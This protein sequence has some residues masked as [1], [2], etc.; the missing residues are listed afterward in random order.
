[1]KNKHENFKRQL[2]I[3]IGFKMI[4]ITSLIVLV[5]FCIM[6]FISSS[7][8]MMDTK[9]RIEENTLEKSDLVALKA[10]GD[11]LSIIER[12]K[13]ALIATKDKLQSKQKI[14]QEEEDDN[15]NFSA[16]LFQKDPN[17]IFIALL[18]NTNNNFTIT[19]SLKNTDTIEKLGVNEKTFSDMFEAE[20]NKYYVPLMVKI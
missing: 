15:A 8:F 14:M 11:F 16:M 2:L 1:M 6:S 13:L 10:T 7:M 5:T 9:V 19:K 18:S 4:T 20:K 3:S 17:T 12:G